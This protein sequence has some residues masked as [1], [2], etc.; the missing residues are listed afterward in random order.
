VEVLKRR[1]RALETCTRA[2]ERKMLQ[3]QPGLAGGAC[4]ADAALR[5]GTRSLFLSKILGVTVSIFLSPGFAAQ[6]P[7]LL[8]RPG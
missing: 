2:N 6:R 5:A 7:A 1:Y 4:C 8:S 3:R